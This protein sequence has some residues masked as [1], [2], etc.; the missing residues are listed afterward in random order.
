[1]TYRIIVGFLL[2]SLSLA[3]VLIYSS[4]R[5]RPKPVYAAVVPSRRPIIGGTTL[6]PPALPPQTAPQEL[7]N[8]INF[9]K[10]RLTGG[11]G[12]LLGV[13][14]LE[15]EVI[16]LIAGSPAEAAGFRIGDILVEVDGRPTSGKP[17]K[18][19]SAQ[20]VG[21]IGTSITVQ[22]R[23][24]DATTRI[25]TVVRVKW[26]DLK[27]LPMKTGFQD[28]GASRR[29]QGGDLKPNPVTS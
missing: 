6:H 2:A 3:A 22:I 17:L 1:M 26:R 20:F 11:I 5:L 7:A 18:S 27:A 29:E 25:L 28:H 24:P 14:G 12:L 13:S 10:D 4:L 19:V 16:G 9:A 8:P 15:P 23:S 21:S